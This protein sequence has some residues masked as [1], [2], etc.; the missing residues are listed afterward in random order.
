MIIQSG[1]M[2]S[3]NI[4]RNYVLTYINYSISSF[5]TE[6]SMHNGS[7]KLVSSQNKDTTAIPIKPVDLVK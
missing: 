1:A 3:N 4:L 6:Y 5:L 7:A 2:L